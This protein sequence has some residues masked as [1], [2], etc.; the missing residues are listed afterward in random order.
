MRL[1]L[2]ALD[3]ESGEPVRT[4]T[5]AVE[6]VRALIDFVQLTSHRQGMKSASSRRQSG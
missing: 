1:E 4:E 6:R 2:V 3:E 5:I